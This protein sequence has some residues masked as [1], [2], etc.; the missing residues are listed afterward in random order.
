MGR[1]PGWH[2]AAVDPA[3]WLR[4]GGQAVVAIAH[5]LD[6]QHIELT[7]AILAQQRR[8]QAAGDLQAHPWI[9]HDKRRK[10]RHQALG[11]EVF[12]HAQA[13]HAIALL[14]DQHVGGFFIERQDAPRI[15]QQ[16]LTLDRRHHPALVAVKQL[17][18]GAVFQTADLL[19]DRGLSQVQPLGRTSE[20]RA[21]DDGDKTAQQH[22]IEHGH[23]HRIIHWLA[24][25][26]L[27][28]EY[29]S[30]WPYFL[31]IALKR[32]SH[33]MAYSFQNGRSDAGFDSG[34]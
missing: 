27:I 21:I 17:A 3:Q 5:L 14:V 20:V 32:G 1:G 7:A 6:Q 25:L 33:G 34:K 29:P 15:G 8:P 31:L 12:R 10:Q 30:R 9:G 11:G 26:Y 18:S 24:W 16:A 2:A 19:A 22:G 28:S 13:Q 23:H 4:P